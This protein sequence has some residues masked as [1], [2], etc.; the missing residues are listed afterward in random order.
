MGGSGLPLTVNNSWGSGMAVDST[1]T[2]RMI[3]ES[4][5]AWLRDV[6][7]RCGM[8]PRRRRLVRR[9]AEV[10]DGIAAVAQEAHSH[11]LKFGLWVDWTQAA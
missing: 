4:A 7:S 5:E 3:G 1:L 11:R 9:P 8:V 2:R 6:P 10:P